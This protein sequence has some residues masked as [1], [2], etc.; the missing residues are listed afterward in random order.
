[1]ISKEQKKE[2]IS[3]FKERKSSLGIFAVR[4]TA[5]GTVWVG[6]SRNLDANRNGIWFSLRHGLHRD[7]PLQHEWNAQGESAF[8]Y[9]VL[10]QLKDDVPSLLVADLLKESKQR[11]M[12]Q[13]QARGL[14]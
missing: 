14:L 2:A 10:E 6:F 7:Q 1:M 4:C 9:Q 11:W 3:K 13:L 12:S 5:T 8:E